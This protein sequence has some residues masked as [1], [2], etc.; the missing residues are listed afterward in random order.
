MKIIK[1]QNGNSVFELRKNLTKKELR[2]QYQKNREEF[3]K[4]VHKTLK[5]NILK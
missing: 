3:M 1:I 2:K 4:R 5:K